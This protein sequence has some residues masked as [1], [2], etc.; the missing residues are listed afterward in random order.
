MHLRWPELDCGYDIGVSIHKQEEKAKQKHG[1]EMVQQ[2]KEY[3]TEPGDLCW[4]S[5]TPIVEAET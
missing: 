2:V 3:P 5:G 1:S 4:I